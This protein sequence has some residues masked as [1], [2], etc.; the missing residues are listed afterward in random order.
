MAKGP[1]VRSSSLI[2][3]VVAGAALSLVL[4]S[5]SP[6]A[7]MP[8]PTPSPTFAV[9]GDGVLT[10]GSLFPTSGTFSF[11]GAGQVAGVEAA[12]REI[13]AAGG[14]NTQPVA[15]LDRKSVV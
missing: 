8:T 12:V 1:L 5:C 14:V 9:T 7:P 3:A 10:I 13:N 4:S 11:I 2:A 6:G 15:V